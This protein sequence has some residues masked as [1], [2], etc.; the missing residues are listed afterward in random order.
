MAPRARRVSPSASG[1]VNAE[2]ESLSSLGEDNERGLLEEEEEEDEY[3]PA[4]APASTPPLSLPFRLFLCAGMVLVLASVVAAWTLAL[5]GQHL[6]ATSLSPRAGTYSG[7]Q[8][9]NASVH[10]EYTLDGISLV[11]A[12]SEEE[13]PCEHDLWYGQ[14]WA[15]ARA[16]LWQME[17]Q[18]RVGAGS[19][20]EA[21]GE[22]G[23]T[24]DRVMRTLGLHR[25]AQ[26]DYE[27][28]DAQSPQRRSLEA[29]AEGVNAFLDAATPSYLPIEFKLLGLGKPSPWTPADSLVWQK[30][31][32]WDLCGNFDVELQR[33][34]MHYLG[35]VA[36]ERVGELLPPFSYSAFPSILREAELD[37]S[38]SSDFPDMTGVEQDAPPPF[39]PSSSPPDRVAELLR[40]VLPPHTAGGS[41]SQAAGSAGA[42]AAAAAARHRGRS[43]GTVA[44]LLRAARFRVRGGGGASNAWVVNAT[45]APIVA[46]DP[47]LQL[48]APSLWYLQR[49]SAKAAGIEVQGVRD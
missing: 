41:A 6:L 28:M 21:V 8:A 15:H 29:Y 13:E 38:G 7:L 20:S 24:I 10:L 44:R 49:L 3:D 27:A 9:L 42:A 31:M 46:N 37:G 11:T 35:G 47:H 17:F 19:M 36:A 33:F 30:V 5:L 32:A 23:L 1:S 48:L 16:R 40:G 34:R 14:G 2:Y 39:P 26:R 12:H 25:A 22:A 18:R 43:S 4:K 45:P